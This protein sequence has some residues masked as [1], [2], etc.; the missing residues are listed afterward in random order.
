MSSV[1]FVH[2]TG[3]RQKAYDQS[4]NIINGEI[5]AKKPFVDVRRCLWGDR[6][7]VKLNGGGS[8][9]PTYDTARAVGPTLSG[10]DDIV[11][12]WS[13]LY[14]DP[15]YELRLLALRQEEST[16]AIPGQMPPWTQLE[17]AV[18]KLDPSLEVVELLQK[19][20]YEP[21][22]TDSHAS[23]ADS[24]ELKDA[25]RTV[26][27][28]AGEHRAA[29]A[30]ALVASMINLAVEADLPAIDA[31][32]RDKVVGDIVAAL[33]GQERSVAGWVLAPLKG[34][35]LRLG[36]RY[37]RRKRGVI[38]D[39]TYPGTGDILLYQTRGDEIRNFIRNEIEAA[40]EPVTLLAHSLGGIASIDL[41]AMNHLPKVERLIT[42]GTQASLLY[43]LNCLVS[44]RWNE[45]LPEHFPKEWLNI[46]DLRDMLSYIG[47]NVFP[48]RVSDEVVNN[49]QPFPEAHS[50]YWSNPAVWKLIISFLP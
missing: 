23:V 34:M 48:G 11:A 15:L 7:G 12:L 24:G 38:S 36:T 9:I 45:Q 50:A 42:V 39:A 20:G 17:N 22:W 43:E 18:R 35:A 5:K 25:L 8:S 46:Y 26:G 4:F 10:D 13:A 16:E 40:S 37:A 49:G 32:V 28:S 2:G 31:S 3:V 19:T 29:I 21:F 41:L 6:C 33:G 1:I 27:S 14:Q 30:R 47:A 44:L